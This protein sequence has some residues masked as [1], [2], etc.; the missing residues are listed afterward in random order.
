MGRVLL[1]GGLGEALE[2]VDVATVVCDHDASALGGVVART[3]ADRDDRVALL[4]LVESRGL[5]DVVV[6]GIRLDLVVEHDL[7]TLVLDLADE[8]LDDART[9]QT[10]RHQKGALEAEVLGLHPPDDVVSAHTHQGAREGVELLDGKVPDL[11]ELDSHRYLLRDVHECDCGRDSSRIFVTG[12]SPGS[13]C[14]PTNS[15]CTD[16]GS[17]TARTPLTNRPFGQVDATP[18]DCQDGWIRPPWFP[19]IGNVLLGDYDP[20]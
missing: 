5:H 8:F 12:V 20:Q 9:A 19:L 18:P 16:F 13:H 3:T 2:L 14:V 15:P 4:L 11:V 1:V 7:D 17:S 6:L 10:G